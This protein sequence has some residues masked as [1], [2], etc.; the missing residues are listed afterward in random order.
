M[1]GLQ[2]RWKELYAQDLPAM[3]KA[4][5]EKQKW[6]VHLDHCFARII[7]DNAVG[8]NST[9]TEVVKSPAIK[10]MSEQQLKDAIKLAEAIVDGS[11]D[12]N[13]LNERSL[14]LRGKH[15]P[16]KKRKSEAQADAASKKTKRS[17]SGNISTYF[18]PSPGSPKKEV[19][20]VKAFATS[21]DLHMD[22]QL[23]RIVDSKLTPF[24]KQTLGMLCQI[25]RG[26]Y[27][28]YQAMSDYITQTSH[29][30][31]ARAVGNA[32]RNN[33][34]APEVPC[35]RILAADGT[36]GGFGGHWG[37]EG[38][39]ASRKHE[40]LK[41]EGIRFDS[42]VVIA[43][44]APPRFQLPTRRAV[45][46]LA[47]VS[48]LSAIEKQRKAKSD[49]EK[50]SD[51]A[52][53]DMSG[54]LQTIPARNGVA[55][56][57]PRGRTIKIINT[58]GKQVVSTWAFGLGAPPE[59]GE[60]EEDKQELE[61]QVD[62]LKEELSRGVQQGKDG[63]DD[64]MEGEAKKVSDEGSD[65]SKK[66]DTPQDEKAD[67][68]A[69]KHSE[70]A[71]DPPEQ[72]LPDT[73]E[74][75]KSA[76][77]KPEKRTWSSYLPS[78]PY[79]N[80]NQYQNKTGTQA[81]QDEKAEEAQ[82][83]A[84][85]RK[86]SSYLPTGKGFSSYVPNLQMPDTQGVVS[87]F[88]SSNSWDPNKSYAEQL[89]DFSKTPVGAGTLAAA[90]GSGT[91]SSLY[92]AYN[93]YSQMNPSKN[94]QPPM[95]YLSLPHTR[96]ATHRLVPEIN[97]TLLT[98]LRNPLMTLVEDTSPGAHDTL[99][100]ACD[101]NMYAALGVDKPEEHGSCAE[102][103]VLALRELNEKAGLKG[104]K[105]VGADIT[106]N[107]A[108]TPLHL[109]MNAPLQLDTS[110]QSEGSGAKGAKLQVDEPKSKKRS[111]VRIRAERDIVVVLSAC[112]NEIGHQNGGR[113]M[114][115]NFM[116]EEPEEDVSASTSSGKNKKGVPK[117]LD[118]TK[119]RSGE[120][121]EKKA[122]GMPKLRGGPQKPAAVKKSAERKIS[123]NDDPPESELPE[124]EPKKGEVK[125]KAVPNQDQKPK[126]SS[127]SK[128]EE[129]KSQET[130]KANEEKPDET[131]KAKK[132][133]KKL[134]RR[135]ATPKNEAS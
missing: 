9:W 134:E 109:F 114:A 24:R 89:Y 74:S 82:N 69:E 27:S 119:K 17:E 31:C 125:R 11:E 34:F 72:A 108:P 13:P 67:S 65:S 7:L 113:C 47:V 127:S 49:R 133:P 111:Y 28:T 15:T 46:S 68:I 77:K 107:I 117:K 19:S 73:A 64:V 79:R 61:S 102:N 12:I 132:K 87:A 44:T 42:R 37:E 84:T 41:E 5:D 106:V 98:N 120:G 122:T 18:L 101:A 110:A 23:K 93:A 25:P 54:E 99:T 52:A 118:S 63:E 112:P 8:R 40:L 51:F 2:Q 35:H 80:K 58:Y 48:V 124:E 45:A 130:P 92:A 129:T 104:T 76:G 71:D 105:A 3:A 116:V 16:G 56:F 30:T 90:S 10:N 50:E 100:A 78:I 126:A 103:L 43:K 26:R 121:G 66:E 83:E 59:E 36:L 21:H 135:S 33:P 75:S 128:T 14:K 62:E 6:P 29:T 39:Y 115:A 85:S 70:G 38:K 91:A 81:K 53:Q 20:P 4:K 97:D 86:W 22:V 123:D 88:K 57:V 55:T 96:A 32:M 95:E 60:E 1:E 131:P 94:N